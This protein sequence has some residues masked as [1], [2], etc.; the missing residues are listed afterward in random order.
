MFNDCI[1]CY[2]EDGERYK[3][4]VDKEWI[5]DFLVGLN[6]ELDEVRGWLLRTK[7]LPS[8]DEIFVEVRREECCKRVM[9]EEQKPP[10]TSDNLAIVVCGPDSTNKGD[11][12]GNWRWSWLCWDHYQCHNHTRDTC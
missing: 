3:K 4:M 6:K 11:S 7:P 12:H 8:I 1:W 9:L 2:A 5:F 10:P